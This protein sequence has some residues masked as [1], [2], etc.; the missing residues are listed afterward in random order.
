MASAS[1]NSRSFH[2]TQNIG[3]GTYNSDVPT[4]VVPGVINPSPAPFHTTAERVLIENTT[5]SATT[6]GP[7]AYKAE[8][9][10]LACLCCSDTRLWLRSLAFAR[11]VG[12]LGTGRCTIRLVMPVCRPFT[13]L[14]PEV[15][16][17][18]AA[19]SR[20]APTFRRWMRHWG[21]M[22]SL[23]TTALLSQATRRVCMRT[24][25]IPANQGELHR[26]QERGK[27]PFGH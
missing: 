17:S 9:V 24:R 7:G 10:R 5:T 21:G 1:M 15:Q 19:C 14:L 11:Q 23:Q 12:A 13:E 8:Q 25:R 4:G 20:A 18:A 27:V 6:P 22:P 16:P 2:G 26:T 3:P